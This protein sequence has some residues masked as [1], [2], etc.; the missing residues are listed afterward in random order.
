M[1]RREA[2]RRAWGIASRILHRGEPEA[3]QETDHGG[4][5]PETDYR[6]LRQAGGRLLRRVD[7]RAGLEGL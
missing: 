3:L 2:D 6:R 5:L 1:N 7:E 4:E